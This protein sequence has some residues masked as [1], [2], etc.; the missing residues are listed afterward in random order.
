MTV[1]FILY[2]FIVH[3]LRGLPHPT[4]DFSVTFYDVGQGDA[5][6]IRYKNKLALIDTGP[7]FEVG[8][9]LPFD[10]LDV[11]GSSCRLSLVI[12]TH[13]HADHYRGLQRV[14]ELCQIDRLIFNDVGC[15]S[16][17]C[18]EL[19]NKFPEIIFYNPGYAEVFKLGEV[20]VTFFT[21]NSEIY[22]NVDYSNVNNL[23][24]ITLV[25]YEDFEALFLGDSEKEV[26]S[27]IDLAELEK[28]IVGGLDVVKI[29][30]HG[31]QNGHSSE[32]IS[33]LKP[34]NCIVSVGVDNTFGH[35]NPDVINELVALGC[36][37]RRTDREG[38]I[39]FT[40]K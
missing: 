7:S 37:V 8:E 21:P 31:A 35:P 34:E 40:L 17:T 13:P 16:L 10:P 39:E 30:H 26:Q 23:S 20:Q 33:T 36:T 6:L 25:T 9:K 4:S 18:R 2:S 24:V 32:L 1:I 22:S 27:H 3:L 11:F 19:R 28:N 38:D 15:E 14:M 12:I 29:A 5:T